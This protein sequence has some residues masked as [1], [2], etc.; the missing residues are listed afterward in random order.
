MTIAADIFCLSESLNAML[1]DLTLAPGTDLSTL[2]SCPSYLGSRNP[3]L[4]I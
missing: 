2:A 3:G 4:D 1:G